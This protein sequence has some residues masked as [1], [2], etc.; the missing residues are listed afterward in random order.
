MESGVLRT[1]AVGVEWIVRLE[2]E[3]G[4]SVSFGVLRDGRGGQGKASY[5]GGLS[6]VSWSARSGGSSMSL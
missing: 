5:V 1:A 6:E 2:Y 3:I 4:T